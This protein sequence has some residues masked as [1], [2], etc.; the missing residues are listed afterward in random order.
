MKLYEFKTKFMTKIALL[1]TTNK[2]EKELKDVLMTKLNNLR[3]M[4]LPNLVHT[5]YLIIEHENVS[6][7]FKKLCREMIED[8]DKMDLEGD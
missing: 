7:E 3:A 5:L 2:R 1:K 8:I 4:N 6:N